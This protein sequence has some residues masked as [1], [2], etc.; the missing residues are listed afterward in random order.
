M[1]K[2]PLCITRNTEYE[3]LLLNK[4]FLFFFLKL[5]YF[6]GFPHLKENV[7]LREKESTEI[8]IFEHVVL[9]TKLLY[10]SKN[11]FALLSNT[12]QNTHP[13]GIMQ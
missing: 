1:Q 4:T 12:Y 5:D 9:N 13:R 10:K 2:I 8:K 11:G 7:S 3:L 6:Q